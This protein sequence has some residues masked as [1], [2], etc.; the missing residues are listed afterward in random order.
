[1]ATWRKFGAAAIAAFA[2]STFCHFRHSGLVGNGDPPVR[3]LRRGPEPADDDDGGGGRVQP[4]RCVTPPERRFDCG[5]DRALGRLECER[6]SCCYSPLNGSSKAPWC[7]Y[8][9]AYPGYQMGV[10]TPTRRGRAATLSRASSSYLPRDVATLHLEETRH[11]ASCLRLT[12]KDAW[13][14]RYEVELP[15]GVPQGK[16][17]SSSSRDALYTVE[18]QAD[19]FGFIVRR[20]SNGRPVMNSTVAPLLFAE[21]YLQLST[22]L[23]SWLVSGLGEHYTSLLLDLNWTSLTLWNRDMAPHAGA[24][25]YGSHP[26]YVVQEEDGLAHGV[27]LLN[28]NAMEVFLQPLPALTWVSTGGVLDLFVF[29]GPDAQSVV[30]Q[31]LQI[32]GQPAMPPYWSLGFHLCRWGYKSTNATR[33]VARRMHDADFPMDVQWN[34]L[35]YAS[36]GRV[37]TVDPLRFGDLKETVEHFHR[38]GVKYV[39]ILDPG[40]SARSPPGTYRPFD[41]GLKRDVFIKNATGHLLLGEVGRGFG[42]LVA[43]RRRTTSTP[44]CAC[45]QVW[46]GLTAFPDF[47]NPET[48]RWW[49]DCIVDFYS[50]VPVDGLWIDM[51]EPTSF[52]SGSTEGCPDTELENPPYTPRVLGGRLSSWTLCMSARQK[53]SAHYDLHNTALVRARGRRPFV[54]SRSSFPSIG[55]FSGVWTGDVRS[56]WEQLAFSIPS[57]LRLGLFGVPL[58]GAD[59][60]G[61]GGDAGEELCVRWTQLGAFYPFMRNH[62]D[63]PNAPQEPF[64]F[65]AEARAA[66]RDALR[67]RYSLLPF[68]YTLFHHAHA[69]GDTVARPL[70]LE[71]PADPRCRRVDRQFLWGSCLLV[72]PVLEE[73]ASEVSAYL[74]PGTWYDLRSGRPTYSR[75]DDALLPAPLDVINIHVREGHIIPMQEPAL[76]TTAS[77]KKAF[78]LTAAL[79]A[80]GSARGDLFWDD[81]DG[82]DTFQTGNYSYLLFTAKQSQVTGDPLRLNGALDGLVLGGV[83]VLGVPSPPRRVFADGEEVEDFAYDADTKVSRGPPTG[84]LPEADAAFVASRRFCE[85]AGWPCPCQTGSESSGNSDATLPLAGDAAGGPFSPKRQLGGQCLIS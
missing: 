41:D 43:R 65:G 62:N 10:L 70:F 69:R 50:K 67:L 85:S 75:G 20:A 31:Y 18:Y 25:L 33:E 22:T 68:L 66:M 3:A 39:L 12:L 46:P 27:F 64:V 57:V 1:M 11:S 73:G 34:D 15:G 63:R 24:N 60:C 83:R 61:F 26:F 9:R 56:D 78:L 45:V 59:V 49:Q 74:P 72:S 76:T 84:D 71:F 36:Q 53:R 38:S 28:S 29:M 81:G 35:D 42:S 37:F 54:L 19:P 16:S 7:F 52:V 4:P 79:S 30:R 5:R 17:S 58:A 77:R 55:R 80:E 14:E 23:A 47:T 44:P 2:F 82:V 6:R 40:I 48:A 51:N 21:Q 13:S 32:I 8:P